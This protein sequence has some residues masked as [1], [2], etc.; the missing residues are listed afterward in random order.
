M[1][2]TRRV[3]D[4]ALLSLGRHG[5]RSEGL[6]HR[7]LRLGITVNR[8]ACAICN[9]DWPAD[10]GTGDIWIC[11]SCEY[12]WRTRTPKNRPERACPWCKTLQDAT[13]IATEVGAHS[14]HAG[15]PRGSTLW[16]VWPETD[17]CTYLG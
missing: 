1:D 3:R 9:G 4:A 10:N 6:A 8:L 17:D 11:P 14:H 15:D 12:A 16:L 13:E 7:L 5:V 2:Q